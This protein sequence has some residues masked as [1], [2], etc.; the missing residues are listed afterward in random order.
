MV[1][2]IFTYSPGLD[3]TEDIYSKKDHEQ[4]SSQSQLPLHNL[5]LLW[6]GPMGDN[7]SVLTEVWWRQGG[8]GERGVRT[9]A[10]LASESRSVWDDSS[11]RTETQ[12]HTLMTTGEI[13]THITIFMGFTKQY[14][15]VDDTD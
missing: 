2:L 11:H 9:A 8:D 7:M 5:L 13:T 10:R 14:T 12:A 6:I 4:P 3:N 15:S 1:G